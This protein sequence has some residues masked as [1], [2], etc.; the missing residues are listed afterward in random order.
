MAYTGTNTVKKFNE[1]LWYWETAGYKADAETASLT[2][3]VR[4]WKK[5]PK[6]YAVF[7]RRTAGATNAV[8]VSLEGS[9]AYVTWNTITAAVTDVTGT[10]P[11]ES[12]TTHG[13]LV[14]YTGSGTNY[15]FYRYLRVYCTTVGAGNTLTVGVYM[16]FD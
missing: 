1:N 12:P 8:S 9:N 6:H 16:W 15:A 3:T 5:I 11:T 10:N 13:P 7:V 2:L 4:G 14:D